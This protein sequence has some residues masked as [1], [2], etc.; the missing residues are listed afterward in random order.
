MGTPP[1]L[2]LPA[3]TLFAM[4]P[5]APTTAACSPTHMIHPTM[6]AK[7]GS[8]SVS[9]TSNTPKQVS[10]R[11]VAYSGMKSVECTRQRCGYG[12]QE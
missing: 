1:R 11:A 2:A 3:A 7:L 6:P 5:T 9:T 12:A 10:R 8:G 4:Q